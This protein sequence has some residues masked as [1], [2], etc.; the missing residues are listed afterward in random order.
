V[1][2]APPIRKRL[3]PDPRNLD[4]YLATVGR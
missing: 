4:E 3:T 2:G 1:A